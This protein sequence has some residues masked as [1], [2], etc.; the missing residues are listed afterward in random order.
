MNKYDYDEFKET[1]VYVETNS[2]KR[3]VPAIANDL[4]ISLGLAVTMAEFGYFEVTHIK[5]GMRLGYQSERAVS[6]LLTL[7]QFAL[8]AH[9]HGFNWDDLDKDKAIKKISEIGD[10][11]V[12]FEGRTKTTKGRIDKIKISE[13]IDSARVFNCIGEFPWEEFRPRDQAIKNLSKIFD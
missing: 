10:E 9:K 12:P 5:T 6:A 4:T 1:T 11:P 3:K 8:I 13:W 2:G 7:S